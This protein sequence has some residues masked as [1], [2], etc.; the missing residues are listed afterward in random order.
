MLVDTSKVFE[1]AKG[2]VPTGNLYAAIITQAVEDAI[3]GVATFGNDRDWEQAISFCTD[4]HGD[5]RESRETLCQAVGVD[6]DIIRAH[7]IAM[8]EGRRKPVYNGKDKRRTKDKRLQQSRE[9]WVE[10]NT[11][12]A[13]IK[14]IP[15][16]RSSV[17]HAQLVEGVWIGNQTTTHINDVHISRKKQNHLLRLI[18]LLLIGTPRS[19]LDAVPRSKMNLKVVQTRY[20]AMLSERDDRTYLAPASVECRMSQSCCLMSR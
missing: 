13:P 17:V 19:Q 12:H 18:D 16:R 7:V 2:D 15:K 9:R 5:W 8:L 6:P 3:Y 11:P 4:T 14:T 10:R 20:N 1:H